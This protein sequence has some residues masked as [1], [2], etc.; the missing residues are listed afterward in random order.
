[1]TVQKDDSHTASLRKGWTTG[2]C[3]AAAA[4]AATQLLLTGHAPL[5]VKL[6]TPKGV[7][8]D[9]PIASAS[10]QREATTGAAICA[11]RKDAGDDP[12]VTDGI[13]ITA[14]VQRTRQ[15]GI[16]IRGGKG[17]GR[18]TKP[19]LACPVGEAA[20]NPV[21]RAQIIAAVTQTAAAFGVSIDSDGSATNHDSAANDG[22]FVVTISAEDGERIAK[23]TYNEQLGIIGGISILG[24]SGIVEP[25][26]EQALMD[27]TH[28]MLDSVY[29][30]G[31]RIAFLCPGNYGADFAQ[32]TL[33]L[34]LER[35]VKCSNFIGD[36]LDWAIYRGFPAIL[37]VG[38]AGKLVKLAAGVMNTHSAVADGR[39]EIFTAYAALCGA[40]LA[41]LEQL[42]QAVSVESCMA[43]LEQIGLRE[44]VMQRIG[45]A[46]E[47]RLVRR[48]RGRAQIEY[49]MFTNQCGV[50]AQSAG[51]SDLCERLRAESTG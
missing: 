25:M 33:G 1:M 24:T 31:Q 50:L 29:A 21:P 37:L 35:A 12:D 16:V 48:V 26:S 9:L 6:H 5:S 11:V 8:L 38:H 4:Q 45:R 3:A 39:Q 23:Q 18:V 34:S 36:A 22:G 2:S 44:P 20:I 10:W 15:S 17:V 7:V 27:T 42:M 32:R 51:A 13:L 49:L 47:E 19:G 30:Q 43:A 40:P 14:Q 41:T 46:I 28:V